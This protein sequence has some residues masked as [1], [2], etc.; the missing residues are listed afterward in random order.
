MVSIE[1]ERVTKDTL[2]I[3][4]PTNG[5]SDYEEHLWSWTPDEVLAMLSFHPVTVKSDFFNG[6]LLF[7]MAKR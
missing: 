5:G 3:T 1:V 4:I 6:N 7:I 2:L